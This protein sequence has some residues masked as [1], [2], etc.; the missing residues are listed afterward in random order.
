MLNTSAPSWGPPR[1][2]TNMSPS[3][4]RTRSDI[5]ACATISRPMRALPGRSTTVAVSPSWLR[6]RAIENSPWAPAT[7]SSELDPAGNRTALATAALESF[8]SWYC[9]VM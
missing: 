6:H 5:P 4:C 8:A 7:S 2:V 9:P 1:S 3:T